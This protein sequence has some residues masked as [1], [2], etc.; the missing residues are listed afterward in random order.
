MEILNTHIYIQPSHYEGFGLGILEAMAAHT[1]IITS[2]RGEIGYVVG[3]SGIYV[4]PDSTTAIT[5][6]MTMLIA[7]KKSQFYW[8]QKAFERS[9]SFTYE[10]KLQNLLSILKQQ[11]IC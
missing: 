11:A 6:A 7:E 2:D 9:K 10:K 4:D 8:S 1:A 3:D 5:E